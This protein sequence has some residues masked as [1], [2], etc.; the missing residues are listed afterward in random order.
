MGAADRATS[1]FWEGETSRS[2]PGRTLINPRIHFAGGSIVHWADGAN[3]PGALCTGDIFQVVADRRWV[4]FMYS[5]PN[6]IPEH[7]DTVRAGG[8]ARRAFDYDAVYGAF[9]DWVVRQTARPRWSGPPAA[10]S[11]TSEW[12]CDSAPAPG[13]AGHRGG[14]HGSVSA[15]ASPSGWPPTAGIAP[16]LLVRLRRPSTLGAAAPRHRRITHRLEELGAAGGR[17]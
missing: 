3:G 12:S 2:L 13:R 8:S 17:D 16:D 15:P 4:S 6:L 5:Y 10:T 7:P 1:V 14:P 11:S 9:W